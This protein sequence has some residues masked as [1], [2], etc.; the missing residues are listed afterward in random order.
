MRNSAL[1]VHLSAVTQAL[2][3]ACGG[4][5]AAA[6]ECDVSK[7]QL[8]RAADPHHSYT[9]KASTIWHLEQACG[10]PIVSRALFNMNAVKSVSESCP[11]YLGIDFADSATDLTVAISASLKDG[12]ISIFEHRE[13]TGRTTDIQSQL[14]ELG[15]SFQLHLA[16]PAPQNPELKALS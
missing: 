10:Q 7:S 3:E 15:Q 16:A 8:Q 12:K 14:S 4:F 6:L 2:I 11:L 1:T 9:L 5:I 13:L